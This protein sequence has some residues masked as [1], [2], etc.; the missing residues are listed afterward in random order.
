MDKEKEWM[1]MFGFA[2]LIAVLFIGLTLLLGIRTEMHC[3]FSG[4][5]WVK[6]DN[7]SCTFMGSPGCPQPSYVNC[8]AK[9]PMVMM[10]WLK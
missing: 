2:A 3:T 6:G 7:S 4:I 9:I 8:D 5:A 1:W 10:G